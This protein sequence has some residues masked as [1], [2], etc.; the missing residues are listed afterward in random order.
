[1]AATRYMGEAAE[2]AGD[3]AALEL[4]AKFMN[5]YLRTA[6]NARDVRTAYNVLNHYR[7]FAAH[8]LERG[9]TDLVTVLAGYFKYYA[10]TAHTM[11]LGFVTETIAYDLS[12]L[13]ELA[14]G[15]G[16]PVHDA[17]LRLLL[18]VDKPAETVAQETSLRGVRKAQVKLATFYLE[19]GAA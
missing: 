6:L 12:T 19:R 11:D 16:S 10:Q 2:A 18:E 4:C 15:L 1:A 9:R 13:V 7:L 17:V 8:L 14:F 5:T 3:R